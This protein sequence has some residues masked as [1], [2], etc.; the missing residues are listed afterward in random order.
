VPRRARDVC[1]SE[2]ARERV[3]HGMWEGMEFGCGRWVSFSSFLLAAYL[4]SHW[5]TALGMATYG[6]GKHLCTS[7]RQLMPTESSLSC[8]EQLAPNIRKVSLDDFYTNP[9]IW[10]GT[11]TSGWLVVILPTETW[12]PTS[13]H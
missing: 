5:L 13:P 7:L 1:T 9:L 3:H 4:L 2:G 6:D 10:S 11:H 8:V 12:R